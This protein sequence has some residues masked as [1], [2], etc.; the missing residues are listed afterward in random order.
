VADEQRD[1]GGFEIPD[2]VA[3]AAGM[4]EDLDS[5]AV[6]PYRVP[7][8]ARRRRAGAVYLVAAVAVAAGVWVTLP[9]AMWWTAVVPLL[10]VGGYHL[11]AG[12]GLRVREGA[13]LAVAARTVPFAVGHASARLGFTGPLARPVWGVLVFSAEEPPAQRA[14]V[15]VD[16]TTGAVVDRHVEPV[17]PVEAG[18][19]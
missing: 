13:A 10:L 6:G 12:R 15:A 7:D 2:E 19:G 1:L 18:G 14:L 4:P 5:S 17:P 11:I 16:A 9:A 8:T 3:A